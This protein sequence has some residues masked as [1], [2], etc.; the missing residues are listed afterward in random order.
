M[1]PSHTLTYLLLRQLAPRRPRRLQLDPL[2]RHGQRP[3]R[4][5]RQGGCSR[6]WSMPRRVTRV[7]II[8]IFFHLSRA[9]VHNLDLLLLLFSLALH[10]LLTPPSSPAGGHHWEPPGEAAA[11]PLRLWGRWDHP[12][13]P[14]HP[15][16]GAEEARPWPRTLLG[17][18][19]SRLLRVLPATP[20]KIYPPPHDDSM[21]SWVI[22]L[23]M[24]CNLFVIVFIRNRLLTCSVFV[25][26]IS[27]RSLNILYLK[28]EVTIKV[29][30]C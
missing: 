9:L 8:I 3:S 25:I 6:G 28:L 24:A 16:G 26:K 11:A 10:S 2:S 19:S 1:S 27:N 20:T 21:I 12:P 17:P 13:R 30:I 5:H 15:E 22:L 23:Q 7:I 18:R 29:K 4:L 14:Q